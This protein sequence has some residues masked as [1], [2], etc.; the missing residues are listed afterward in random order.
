MFLRDDSENVVVRHSAHGVN[1]EVSEN[2]VKQQ[3]IPLL[4]G[5]KW[6][7]TF[8]VQNSEQQLMVSLRVQQQ[9]YCFADLNHRLVSIQQCSVKRSH[10]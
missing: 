1:G 7:L 8:P 6:L 9:F 10:C 3:D 2:T 5:H 4:F